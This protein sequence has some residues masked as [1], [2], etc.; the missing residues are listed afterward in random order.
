MEEPCPKEKSI[1]E[2]PRKASVEKEEGIGEEEE[3]DFI[4]SLF[5]V[6]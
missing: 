6:S 2:I 3:A 4:S 5:I 1:R